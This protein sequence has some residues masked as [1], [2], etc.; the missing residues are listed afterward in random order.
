MFFFPVLLGDVGVVVGLHGLAS[1]SPLGRADFTVNV[2]VLESLDKSQDFVDVS[3]NRQVVVGGVSEDALAVDD[4]SGSGSDTG[5]RAL[6]DEGA[7]DAGD[8]LGVVCDQRQVDVAKS[9]LVSCLLGVGVV[10]EQRVSRSAQQHAVVLL[11]LGVSIG[12][13]QDL[14]WAHESEVQR[15]E[16]EHN[17]LALVVGQLDLLGL[18]VDADSGLEVRSRL[19]D[20]SSWVNVVIV[21]PA[22]L[23]SDSV[24]VTVVSVTV[25][26]VLTVL[27]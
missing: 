15:V 12:E 26:L 21:D 25:L 19:L 17:V 6:G 22:F 7:V 14:S 23:D 27:H 13:G 2:S 5:I 11:E 18:L 20:D 10:R 9:A 16:E 3:A 1:R 4:E 8:G 24:V